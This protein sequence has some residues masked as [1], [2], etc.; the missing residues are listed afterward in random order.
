MNIIQWADADGLGVFQP[1]KLFSPPILKEDTE[2]AYFDRMSSMINVLTEAGVAQEI[3]EKMELS[4]CEI[5]GMI[6][7]IT[8]LDSRFVASGLVIHMK[9]KMLH[10]LASAVE[11]IYRIASKQDIFER[12]GIVLRDL[13]CREYLLAIDFSGFKRIND[14][15]GHEIGDIIICQVVKELLANK[16]L[17]EYLRQNELDYLPVT[18]GGDE[19]LI[20]ITIKQKFFSVSVIEKLIELIRRI[21]LDN[22]EIK[23]ALMFDDA[24][25]ERV[26][27]MGI[28]I[29]DGFL[30]KFLVGIGFC[31][32][33]EAFVRNQMNPDRA[34][35]ESALFQAG[36][37]G[38]V[39]PFL[40]KTIVDVWLK[41]ADV[42]SHDDKND[43]RQ[44]LLASGETHNIVQAQ[45]IDSRNAAAVE[46]AARLRKQNADL[47]DLA[48]L[49]IGSVDV[50]LGK[51][52]A[53]LELDNKEIDSRL[54]LI[55]NA[56]EEIK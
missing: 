54:R 37:K 56:L 9:S 50:M 52:G 1:S 39:F 3:I 5:G 17:Q 2:R 46:E 21:L 11:K 55:K 41:T 44:E 40:I 53:G 33:E 24:A 23:K 27:E 45:L 25:K 31:S 28:I 12:G 35:A 14:A 15:F 4:L 22:V 7:G 36:K 19:L 49:A 13:F 16:E 18:A 29:P 48:V 30:F 20:K 8:S 34:A 32:L 10:C 26:K 47:I 43:I 42:A 51:L 38:Q 6:G